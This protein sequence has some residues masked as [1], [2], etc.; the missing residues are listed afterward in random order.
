V[1]FSLF[2]PQLRS[3]DS[4]PSGSVL[5]DG[6]GQSRVTAVCAIPCRRETIAAGGDGVSTHGHYAH[7]CKQTRKQQFMHKYA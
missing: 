2:R 6:T 5:P 4:L 3:F 7:V 1:S